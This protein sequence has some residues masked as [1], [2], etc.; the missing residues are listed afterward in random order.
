MSF[1]EAERDHWVTEKIRVVNSI[2][3][4]CSGGVYRKTRGRKGELN[5]IKNESQMPHG[6]RC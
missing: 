5:I 2:K 1:E 3:G 4:G 6:S